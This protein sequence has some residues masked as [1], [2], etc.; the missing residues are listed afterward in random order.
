MVLPAGRTMVLREGH[1]RS[2]W[3]ARFVA[4]YG[5][6]HVYQNEWKKRER[7]KVCQIDFMMT[8]ILNGPP[9][10]ADGHAFTPRYVVGGILHIIDMYVVNKLLNRF[11]MLY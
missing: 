11:E 2:D 5:V 4:K 8:I 6:Y 10:A 3:S 7:Q 9:K 1:E